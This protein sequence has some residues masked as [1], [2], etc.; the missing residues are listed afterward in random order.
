MPVEFIGMV[1]ASYYSESAVPSGPPIDLPYLDRFVRAYED[2]GFDWT[3]VSYGSTSPESNQLAAAVLARTAR[4]KVFLAHRPGVVHPT[5][6]AR[7]FATLQNLSGGRL[8]VH[9]IT[10]GSDA[11]QRREGDYLGKEDRYRRSTEYVEILRA[12]WD[13]TGPV[14]HHG[15]F[16]DFDDAQPA[17]RPVRPIPLSIGGS[18]EAAYALGGAQGDIFGLWGEPLAETAQ[19]IAAVNQYA[20]K[21]GRPHPRIWMSLRPIVAATD[22]LA[23]ERAERILGGIRTNFAPAAERAGVPANVG[24][25]RLLAAASRKDVHDRAL[26]TVPAQATNAAG[27]STALVGSP[28]TVAAALLDYVDLGC[29]LIS[30]RGYDPLH[31]AVDLARQVIPLVRRGR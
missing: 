5:N 6:A 21:A 25:Q 4:L 14:S 31:D 27:A 17:I 16:Y 24:S 10:G 23:W 26:W 8:G 28:D 9:I 7:T 20:D 2:G 12:L 19:Q 22:A 15:E 3:L 29:D 13:A 18:S 11:E 1:G 30:I